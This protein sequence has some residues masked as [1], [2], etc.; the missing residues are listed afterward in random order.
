MD[1]SR[2]GRTKKI[3]NVFV[4]KLRQKVKDTPI[5]IKNVW[6]RGYRL[7]VEEQKERAV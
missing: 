1:L 4:C 6:G 5:K 7:I 3:I 2:I